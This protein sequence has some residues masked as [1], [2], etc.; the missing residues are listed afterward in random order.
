[1]TKENRYDSKIDRTL[2]ITAVNKLD[3]DRPGQ[4]I[5]L[6]AKDLSALGEKDL[7]KIHIRDENGNEMLCQVVDTDG[8]Y[9]PDQLIFQA[10]F[11]VGQTRTFT[12]TAGE[13]RVYSKDQ[14]RAYGR[15]VR[16]R[17][18][19]FCW[20]ND[21]IAF[22]IY[23][24]T[25]ETCI[26]Y[27]LT[28]STVD[29]WSKRTTRMVINDWYM[30]DN[31]HGDTGEGGDFYTAGLSRGCGGSG[32]W[33]ADKLWVSKNFVSSRPLANGPIRVLFELTYEPFEVNGVMVSE[34]K[35]ISLD[36][37]QNLTHY[38]SIYKPEKQIELINGV[39]LKKVEGESYD[40]NTER[41]WLAKWEPMEMNAG[42]QGLASIVDA[43]LYEKQTE[44]QLNLLM[45]ARVPENS[46]ASYWAGFCWDKSGQFADY[47]AWK[48]YVDQFAQGLISPIE[49]SV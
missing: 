32:L 31:Y 33:V 10:D 13:K 11:D 3:I 41:G 9:I 46:T 38:Q 36:A 21:R 20:E 16:E 22:R 1:M 34:V 42:E 4:T 2:K 45:L 23:G 14:F 6:S 44:D 25:L 43:K 15:F 35:R 26:L 18:D 49:V 29:I 7:T 37:G 8:D 28:S 24:K 39:G 48:K 5:E 47:E 27:P 17:C 30:V 19:D 40:V 12:A